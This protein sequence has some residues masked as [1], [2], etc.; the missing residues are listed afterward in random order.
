MELLSRS[1]CPKTS[2]GLVAFSAQLDPVMDNVFWQHFG[3]S[4][5]Y[6]NLSEFAHNIDEADFF[7]EYAKKN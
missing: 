2:K 4:W 1:G 5:F 6:P 3:K 7:A